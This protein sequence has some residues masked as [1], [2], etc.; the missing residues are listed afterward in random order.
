MPESSTS[1]ETPDTRQDFKNSWK[2]LKE[3]YK[4]F[5]FTEI[6]AFFA[7]LMFIFATFLIVLLIITLLPNVTLD[8]LGV[9]ISEKYQISMSFRLYFVLAFI[10]IFMGF[11]NSQ[12]GLANDIMNSGEMFA[13]FK[14]S[15]L[16][17]K[18]NW[19][20]YFI[21]TIV[22]YGFAGFLHGPIPF[23][24]HRDVLPSKLFDLNGFLFILLQILRILLYFGWFVLTIHAF[25]S[26][27]SQNK[28][29]LSLKETFFI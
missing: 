17:F 14:G 26:V 18:K 8:E 4:A 10:T 5:I 2:M 12:F 21:L 23:S 19:W 1:R 25:A 22:V 11:I 3:N 24:P 6:F 13:E 15:F 20:Q 16:Y 29:K 9:L 27:T 7:F 28:L